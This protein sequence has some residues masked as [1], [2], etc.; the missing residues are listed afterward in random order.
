MGRQWTDNGTDN[1]LT[2]GPT[3]AEARCHG[4]PLS[5]RLPVCLS[6]CLFV[7]LSLSLYVPLLTS[8]SSGCT[9]DSMATASPWTQNKL[10]GFVAGIMFFFFM[11]EASIIAFLGFGVGQVE[12]KQSVC[13]QKRLIAEVL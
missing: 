1:G 13:F 6:V 2:I 10:L 8:A 11:R 7:C 5:I 4:L 3:E 9:L 12:H